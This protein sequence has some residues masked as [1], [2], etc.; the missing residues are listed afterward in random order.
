MLK[1]REEISGAGPLF[2]AEQNLTEKTPNV[3]TIC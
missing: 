3:V 1:E 2:D